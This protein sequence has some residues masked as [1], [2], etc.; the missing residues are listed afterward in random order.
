MSYQQTGRR[1]DLENRVAAVEQ[2]N[3]QLKEG[4]PSTQYLFLN[5][6]DLLF[7]A[8]GNERENCGS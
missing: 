3:V 8:C 4:I 7:R 6:A 5:P 2:E 1:V